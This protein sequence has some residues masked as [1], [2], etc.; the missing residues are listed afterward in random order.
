MSLG[1][2][3]LHDH[4]A[5]PLLPLVQDL[6]LR[7]IPFRADVRDTL[8]R[9]CESRISVLDLE[10]F[11]AG[12]TRPNSP[13]AL[14]T[15]LVALGVPLE[16]R[17]QGGTQLVT[18][19]D[20]L[21]RIDHHYNSG[22]HPKFPFLKPLVLRKKLEKA[23]ANLTSIVP[24][25]DGRVRTALRSTGTET[26]R[27]SSARLGWCPVCKEA[28]HGANVQN[29]AKND[30]ETGINVRDCF[31]AEPGWTF[32]ELDFKALEM[33][34][35]AYLANVRLLIERLESGEDLHKI[36]AMELFD[37]RYND[38][39]RTLAKNHFFAMQYGGS[40]QAIQMALSKKGEYLEQ[41]FIL[42]LMQKVFRMYP[43][44][45]AWQVRM[46]VYLADCEKRRAPKVVRN[47]F[48]RCRVLLGSD[49]LKEALSTQIQGTAADVMSFALLRTG[50]WS[51]GFL[52]AQIHDAFLAYV[53]EKHAGALRAELRQEMERE[54][55]LGDRFVRFPVDAKLGT[56]WSEMRAV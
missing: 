53:P 40:E 41:A 3:Q 55:W 5:L 46:G 44:M 11:G 50:C 8:V 39:L 26:G 22:E 45:P 10:L 43:E 24:C 52:V 35:M 33:R 16:K 17:T 13:R 21:R 34:I 47:A 25:K 1:V 14:G 15:E 29:F 42:S 28:M 31:V 23:R 4:L 38:A 37:G 9:E 56:T 27:Y 49:P 19:L 36:H 32:V 6:G 12:I 18:D 20:V 2:R 51:L 7:G 54:V 48:G 30:T